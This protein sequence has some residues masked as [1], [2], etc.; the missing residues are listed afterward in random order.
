MNGTAMLFVNAPELEDD[1]HA[2]TEWVV[3]HCGER[4]GKAQVRML[5]G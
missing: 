3:A 2:A 1:A 5:V 4:G